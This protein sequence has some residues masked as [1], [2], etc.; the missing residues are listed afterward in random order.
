MI[1][2]LSILAAMTVSDTTSWPSYGGG[3]QHSA[4]YYGNSQSLALDHW[5]AGLDDDPSYYGGAVLIHYASP[6]VTPLNNVVYAYRFNEVV[7]GNTTYNNWHVIARDSVAGNVLYTVKTDFQAPVIWPNDWTSVFPLCLTP[8][9]LDGVWNTGVAAGA[10]GGSVL[11]L[12]NADSPL[13]T[14]NRVIFYTTFADYTANASN[15]SNIYIDT[16]ITPDGNGNIYFGYK[17]IGSDPANFPQLGAGGLVKMNVS[18]HQSQYVSISSLNIPGGASQIQTNA[19]PALS[20]DGQHVYLGVYYDEGG[21]GPA[22]LAKVNASTLALEASTPL[23]DPSVPGNNA[24]LIQESSAAPMVAPDGHVYMGAFRANYGESHGWMFQTDANLNTNDQNGNP[25]PIGAF[26]WDDTASV[27]PVSIVP[28]YTGSASYLLL[29][30][31]N[32]YADFHNTDPGAIGDNKVA[33][34]DPTSNATGVD[35]QTGVKVMDVVMGIIGPTPDASLGDLGCDEWCINSAA[36][37]VNKHS[38]IINSEDGHVYRWDFYTNTLTDHHL[39]EPPTGE[40]Y[41]STVI[42]PDGTI[43]AINNCVLFAIGDNIIATAKKPAAK[44]KH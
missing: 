40:A 7:G 30:K 2:A 37:D 22:Y 18:T 39:L 3:P 44:A 28:S 25:Y 21:S 34:L 29:T 35:R 1:V 41:T 24:W 6:V 16:P 31:Y 17:V 4:I 15:Y 8:V 42:G 43:Y 11:I 36:V 23:M 10:A 5:H 9:K 32:D 12:S 33:L 19:S 27:V 20:A 26:G 38:A 13:Y 14:Q